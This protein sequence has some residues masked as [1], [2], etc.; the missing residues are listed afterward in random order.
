[1][2]IDVVV[3]W[4]TSVI[5]MQAIHGY[6]ETERS[7][8]N[9]ENSAVIKRIKETAFLN[10]DNPPTDFVHVLDLEKDGVIKPH[11]DSVRVGT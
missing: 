6:R 1:M 11:K 5:L 2:I 7:N 3:V 8:W 9:V 10:D 4:A